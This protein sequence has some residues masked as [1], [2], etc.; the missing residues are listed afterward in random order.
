MAII[1]IS[2]AR[3]DIEVA[4]R[5]Y[6][7]LKREG[8]DPW[9]DRI[10]MLPGDLWKRAIRLAS[11]EVF[12][13]KGYYS[14]D[15]KSDIVVDLAIEVMLPGASSWS[16]LWIWECK[17]HEHPVPVG[18]VEEFWAKLQQIGGVNVK[19]G[20]ATT[21]ALQPEALAYARAKGIAVVRIIGR[22]LIAVNASDG[23]GGAGLSGDLE[24]RIITTIG[25][26][27]RAIVDPEYIALGGKGTNFLAIHNG[28]MFES[29]SSLLLHKINMKGEPK[30][31][32]GA[33]FSNP[34]TGFRRKRT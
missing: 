25:D 13:H 8:H 34:F 29:W 21:S 33:L 26:C 15:R 11:S 18:D 28:E 22:N 24:D 1:F 19:G 30:K 23:F 20:I 16:I 14:R 3:E 6:Y 9:M 17:D 4:S 2:Y 31:K 7:D 10:D 32:F 5:L 12:L 27:S